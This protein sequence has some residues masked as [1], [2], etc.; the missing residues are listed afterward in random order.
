MYKKLL[1]AG[2]CVCLAAGTLTGCGSDAGKTVAQVDDTKIEYSLL[3][4]M[5]RYNQA[6]M[7]TYYGS[8]LGTDYWTSYGES[9][10]DGVLEDLETMILLEKHMDDYG[11]SLSDEEKSAV[12]EA[13]TAFMEANDAE[14]LEAMTATQE[15]VERVLTLYTV[16]SKMYYAIIADVDTNVT[17]EEAAQKTVQYVFFSTA[18]TTDDDGNTVAR[19]DEEK[20]EIKAQAQE[21]LDAVK[22]GTDMDEA[23]EAVDDSKTSY[24]TSYGADNGTLNDTLKEEAEKLTEDGQAAEE[25][26]ETDSGYYVLKMVTLFDEEETDEYKETIISERKSDLYSEVTDG[27]LEA[28]TVTKND[29]VLEKMDFVDTWELKVETESEAETEDV[30]EAETESAVETE[31]VTDAAE[32]E[33]ASESE[34]EVVTDAETDA[35]ETAAETETESETA[36]E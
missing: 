10:R 9:S 36:A 26:I 28:A 29:K 32:T 20:A 22:A 18:D 33:T 7:Q 16:Q 11:V 24:T 17:D 2:L 8:F 30:S 23:L 6:Q 1:A 5:L 14:T 4:F 35:A 19:T 12:T 25:V 31:V 3:N 27:Y 13:A 15:I 21:V 34:T